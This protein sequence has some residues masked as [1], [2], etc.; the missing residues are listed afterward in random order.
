MKNTLDIAEELEGVTNPIERDMLLQK[1]GAIA[2]R[3]TP[4]ERSDINFESAGLGLS[5]AW[6]K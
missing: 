1:Y 5:Y 6:E 2:P 3:L 4:Q